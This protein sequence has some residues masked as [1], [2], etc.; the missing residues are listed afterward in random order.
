M[1]WRERERAGHAVVNAKVIG[2]FATAVVLHTLWDTFSLLRGATFVES[3]GLEL[4]SI[5]IAIA[6]LTLLIRR[7]REASRE[8]SSN[9]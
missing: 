3:V 8:A 4:L 6:S 5:L 1:L 7:I 9:R 2:A